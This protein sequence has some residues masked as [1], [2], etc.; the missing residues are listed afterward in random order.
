[1]SYDRG[2]K[3]GVVG[4]STVVELEQLPKHD[5]GAPAA[6]APVE[7]V[8]TAAAATPNVWGASVEWPNGGGE[9]PDVALAPGL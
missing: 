3:L 1:M 5:H 6:G 7:E 8:L 2:A 9:E 4:G